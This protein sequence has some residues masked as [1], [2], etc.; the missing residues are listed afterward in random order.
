MNR[1]KVLIADDHRLT[2]TA[3]RNIFAVASDMEIAGEA[4][5]AEE[6]FARVQDTNPDVIVLD[7]N[8]PGKDGLE[9]LRQL[10][11]E[12]NNIPIVILTLFP[13]ERFKQAAMQSGAT[14]FLSK[15]CNP[16]DL[17]EAVRKAKAV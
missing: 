9:I 15:D 7:V 2:R 1:I 13:P 3:L 12:G 10:R 5:N 17:L 8:M 16:D 6:V 4:T 11:S 14:N